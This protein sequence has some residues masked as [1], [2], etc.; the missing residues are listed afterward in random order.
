[1][2]D[3]S[4]G[5]P[6]PLPPFPPV[7]ICVYLWLKSCFRLRFSSLRS[8]ASLRLNFVSEPFNRADLHGHLFCAFSYLFVAISV[9]YPCPSCCPP[10]KIPC[11]SVFTCPPKLSGSSKGGSAVQPLQFLLFKIRV[12][13]FVVAAPL[14][15]VRLAYCGPR[16]R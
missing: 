7:K 4:P 14:L 2:A 13:S 12:Y 11:P 8:V 6:S 3:E 9:V 15:F 10:A 1:M 16:N 5:F